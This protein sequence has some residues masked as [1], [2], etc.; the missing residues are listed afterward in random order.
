MTDEPGNK[1]AARSALLDFY[2]DRAVSFGGFFLVSLFGLVTMLALVQGIE[3]S[4]DLVTTSMV[5][6]SLIP[7]LIFAIMG[8]A[9]MQRYIHYAGIASDIE[10]GKGGEKTLRSIADLPDPIKDNKEGW[11]AKIMSA[12]SFKY[13]YSFLIALLIVVVY[14]PCFL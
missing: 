14:V 7:F 3:S 5:G 9:A 2:S 12:R 1:I 10:G 6:L 13:G 4:R 11:L 8:Y